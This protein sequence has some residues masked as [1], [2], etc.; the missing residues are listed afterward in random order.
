MSLDTIEFENKLFGEDGEVWSELW[1]KTPYK[2]WHNAEDEYGTE[3]QLVIRNLI[4]TT[5]RLDIDVKNFNEHI[6]S[7]DTT[8]Q[9]VSTDM[10]DW[11]FPWGIEAKEWGITIVADRSLKSFEVGYVHTTGG[12]YWE[13][14]GADYV[15]HSTHGSLVAAMFVAY[16]MTLEWA[17]NSQKEFEWEQSMDDGFK[18]E[19]H[20]WEDSNLE[21]E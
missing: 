3:D 13:P 17:Y 5:A 16:S 20:W 15:V 4:H 9:F 7:L 10:C 19:E 12:S 1:V 11:D 2:D 14:P 21:K 18:V 6:K 8:L